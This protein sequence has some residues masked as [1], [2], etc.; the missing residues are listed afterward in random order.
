M[1]GMT[2][3]PEGWLGSAFKRGGQSRASAA[4]WRRSRF[5]GGHP[6]GTARPD[7][8]LYNA[9]LGG[10]TFGAPLLH[11]RRVSV[12]KNEFKLSCR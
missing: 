2:F 7:G 11:E 5:R 8:P 1:A 9:Q 12:L 6:G 4:D 3:P 10:D